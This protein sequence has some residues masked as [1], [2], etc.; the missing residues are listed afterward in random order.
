MEV[1]TQDYYLQEVFSLLKLAGSLS[2]Q[3]CEMQ[4]VDK[5]IHRKAWTKLIDAPWKR[6]MTD[7]GALCAAE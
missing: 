1:E 5:H 3:L 4:E 7:S 2:T 6:F